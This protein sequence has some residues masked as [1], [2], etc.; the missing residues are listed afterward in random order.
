MSV[1]LTVV[2]IAIISPFWFANSTSSESPRQRHCVMT[3]DSTPESTA[4]SWAARSECLQLSLSQLLDRKLS[5]GPSFDQRGPQ[6]NV[7][8]SCLE[9]MFS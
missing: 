6:L 8:L 7:A 5:T 1:R 4:I 3:N 9:Y 2:S